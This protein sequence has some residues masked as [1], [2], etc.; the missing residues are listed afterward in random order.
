MCPAHGIVSTAKWSLVALSV[1]NSLPFPVLG[2]E[3]TGMYRHS[4]GELKLWANTFMN[5]ATGWRRGPEVTQEAAAKS[6]GS[7]SQEGTL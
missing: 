2:S 6:S 1:L 5:D 4:S 3:F 7:L